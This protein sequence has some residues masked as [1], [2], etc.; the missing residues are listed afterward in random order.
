MADN[1]RKQTGNRKR[2]ERPARIESPEISLAQ[3]L[4]SSA[5]NNEWTHIIVVNPGLYEAI[6]D[7]TRIEVVFKGKEAGESLNITFRVLSDNLYGITS[8]YALP[9]VKRAICQALSIAPP[10]DKQV[11]HVYSLNRTG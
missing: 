2:K 4:F 5:L 10:L 1:K 7:G 8:R 6:P 3:C 11:A 9:Y